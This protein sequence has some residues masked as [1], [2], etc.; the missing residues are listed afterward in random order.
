MNHNRF[1]QG[2]VFREKKS[3]FEI[4]VEK[5][6]YSGNTAFDLMAKDFNM[7]KGRGKNK[8]PISTSTDFVAANPQYNG[9]SHQQIQ[10]MIQPYFQNAS[11]I[12]DSKWKD[13]FNKANSDK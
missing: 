11:K 4:A 10:E 13:F 6:I 8:T 5:E 12:I 9:Y 7:W 2:N 1:F 3:N